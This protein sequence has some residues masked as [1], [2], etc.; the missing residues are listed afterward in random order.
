MQRLGIVNC[1]QNHLLNR[2]WAVLLVVAFFFSVDSWG[3]CTV[4]SGVYPCSNGPSSCECSNNNYPCSLGYT[5]TETYNYTQSNGFAGC[6]SV[7]SLCYKSAYGG[8]SK[9][10]RCEGVII[11]TTQCERDSVSCVKKNWDWDSQNC[12]CS[13]PS[14]CANLRAQC[15][16]VGGIFHGV[17]SVV[18]GQ[19]CCRATCNVCGGESFKK[20]YEMK[21][22]ICCDRM[23]APPLESSVCSTV[24]L[25][26]TSCGMNWSRYSELTSNEWA[27]RDPSLSPEASQS[28]NEQCF[29]ISSSSSDDPN[30]A[31][32]SSGGGGSSSSGAQ[33]PEDC[34]ECPWLDSILDTLTL[35]KQT[36]EAIYNCI[37]FPGLCGNDNS[38]NINP[39]TPT[40]T[41]ILPFIL[42]YLDTSNELNVQ[43]LSELKSI[44]SLL[45]WID[46][47]TF[48]LSMNDSLTW[49]AIYTAA[50]SIQQ[51]VDASNDTTRKWMSRIFER[52]KSTNDTLIN[53]LDS[54]NFSF[55]D[56]S[57]SSLNDS[58]VK[59]FQAVLKYDSIYNKVFKDSIKS[60][61]DA[62]TD[63]GVN[64][65]YNLG[66]GDTASK[67]LRNDL[68]GI[69]GAVDSLHG[70][71]DDIVGFLTAGVADSS[72]VGYA[73]GFVSEGERIG[74]SIGRAVGWIGGL[75]G[76][77]VDSVFSHST[78]EISGVDSVND[79]VSDTL[80]GILDSLHL[81]LKSENDSIISSLPD[82]LTVWADSL[83][84][85]SPFVSFDSLIYSTLGAKIP[86]SDQCPEGCQSWSLNLPRFGLINYTVDFGL[87]LGRVPLGGLNVLGFLRLIIRL[88]IV[89]TCI[90]VVMWNF[91]QRKM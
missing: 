35:Q 20:L 90:S 40:D 65:G 25:P 77:N 49:S 42:P 76:V 78:W 10:L 59:Y 3:F 80:G 52:I 71:I 21:R 15:S 83:I 87:C 33:Y 28:Y 84:K 46:Y 81:Q 51:H 19:N 16:E 7:I 48:V 60:I 13:D 70:G 29:E 53:H 67:T 45:E 24:D 39:P 73:S 38:S 9:D 89:W 79:F 47:R 62:I 41:N 6:E 82:S 57:I 63:I 22:Q 37:I 26:P 55:V 4:Q 23:Q 69:K 72:T 31:N 1:F 43:Q 27:C 85:V 8:G 36:V 11:C 75:D 18:D 64:I 91:S 88:V 44:D 74:D 34:P 50:S 30:S 56:T 5:C 68:E 14:I 58:A 17:G 66:Y 12:R 54:L 2:V 32:S 86:N 61:H